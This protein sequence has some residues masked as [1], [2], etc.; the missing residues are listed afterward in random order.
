[1]GAASD[2][3]E[4]SGVDVI[5]DR[6]PRPPAAASTEPCVVHLVRRGTS[7]EPFEEFLA[8]YDAHPAGMPHELAIVFKGFRTPSET[9]PHLRHAGDR[10]H[11]VVY[12]DDSGFDL[13]AYFAAAARLGRAR[14]CFLNSYSEILVDG[15]LALLSS[16]LDDPTVG[17]VGATGSCAS[18]RSYL[19]YH[20]GLGGTYQ[21]ILGDRTH[22]RRTLA[23]LDTHRDPAVDPRWLAGK[24]TTAAEMRDQAMHFESFP[25]PHVRTNAFMLSGEVCERISMS[26]LKRKV[27]AYRVESGRA[28]ITR[29]VE[30][31]GLRAVVVSRD[32]VI[33]DQ[34]TWPGSGVFWQRRQEGLIVADNQTRDYE[35]GDPEIRSFLSRYAWGTLADPA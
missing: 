9:E 18:V 3:P 26:S 33:H 30:K 21:H 32:G 24:L 19:R 11:E 4:S 28:S 8:S 16:A 25:S 10:V 2:E 20:L 6:S 5:P 35:R 1:V 7:L 29:Q 27:D 23:R 15:W 14:Y 31:L 17:V 13:T 22:A 34:D 12:V